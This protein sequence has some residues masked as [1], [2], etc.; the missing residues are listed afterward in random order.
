M[1]NHNDKNK[2]SMLWM[3][4]PCLLI[5]GFALFSGGGES[6]SWLS[7]IVIG[8]MVGGHLW[9]M[10]RGHGHEPSED[11]DSA[12]TEKKETPPEDAPHADE[13]KSR[14]DHSCCN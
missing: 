1:R 9:M 2:F 8:A 4:L 5:L 7:I 3:M 14:S 13:K 10:L 12:T 11:E 6:R